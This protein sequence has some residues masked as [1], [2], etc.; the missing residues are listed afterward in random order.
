MRF[1]SIAIA[2]LLTTALALGASAS[3]IN[4]FSTGADDSGV[5]LPLGTPDSH[6]S[7]ISGPYVGFVTAGTA[8]STWV[9]DSATSRWITP[10]NATWDIG[11]YEYQTTFSLAGLDPASAILTGSWSADNSAIIYL[12]GNATSFTLGANAYGSFTPFTLSSGF[13]NGVNTLDF[14]VYNDGG[15]TGL[16]VDISG[17]ASPV[18]EPSTM[19]L[20]LGGLLM[21]ALV[22]A[23]HRTR[24]AEAL[25]R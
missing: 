25:T 3:S 14:F 17:T 19:W 18:P 13:V 12:N 8:S 5:R 2:T 11:T 10:G 20:M 16:R 15:P 7:L 4:V 24:Q 21:A 1:K 22:A 9:Q 23:A 6:Y